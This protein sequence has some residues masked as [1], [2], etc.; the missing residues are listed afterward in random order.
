[1]TAAS[2][3]NVVAVR[4]SDD[5][6]MVSITLK[7]ELPESYDDGL[8]IQPT[9]DYDK[10]NELFDA[11]STSSLFL[12]LMIGLALIVG[13]ASNSVHLV[14]W[15]LWCAV[16]LACSLIGYGLWRTR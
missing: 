10:R 8:V 16:V 12:L 4:I 1:M 3:V 9:K 15:T 13:Y 2:G 7:D 5:R 11:A 14:T 6:T